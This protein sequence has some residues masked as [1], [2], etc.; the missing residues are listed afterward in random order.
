[1]DDDMEEGEIVEGPGGPH[2]PADDAT[3]VLVLGDRA[4]FELGPRDAGW[5]PIL[6]E[7]V[8][9]NSRRAHGLGQE[10][11]CAQS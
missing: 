9:T 1:V 2:S 8:A 11:C 7:L 6:V 3:L 10:S 5:D 4:G